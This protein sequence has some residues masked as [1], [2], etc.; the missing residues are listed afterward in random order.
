MLITNRKSA[1]FSWKRSLQYLIAL[2]L[3]TA[4]AYY[5]LWP[6]YLVWDSKTGQGNVIRCDME[7]YWNG[8][9][10]ADGHWFSNG[11]TRSSDKAHSGKY[12]SKLR[13][14][15]GSFY[16]PGIALAGVE[17]GQAYRISLWIN[18]GNKNAR[19]SLVASAPEQKAFY[20]ETNQAVEFAKK[21]WEQLELNF[22]LPATYTHKELEVY[23]YSDGSEAVFVDDLEIEKIEKD[24]LLQIADNQQ[25]KS[26]DL[27][28]SDKQMK[29]LRLARSRAFQ[30]GIII[31][32]EDSWA[33]A[34]L[35]DDGEEMPV[36]LRLKGDWLDHLQGDKWS[37]RIKVKD[38]FSWQGLKTFSLHTPKARYYLWE[39]LIHKLWEREDVLAPR[40]DFVKLS[41]NGKA[42]GLYAYE[43][44]FDKQLV[45]SKARREGPII[46]MSE[47]AIWTMRARYRKATGAF[48]GFGQMEQ[49]VTYAQNAQVDAFKEN[50]IRSSET[51][52]QQFEIGQ[53]LL[54]QFQRGA[55][56]VDQIFD[57]DRLARFYA[58][59]D[60]MGAWH[61]MIWHNQ[62]YYYNPVIS[63]LEPIGY[64]AYGGPPQSPQFYGRTTARV[65]RGNSMNS[66]YYLFQNEEFVSLYLKY[67]L[68]Y[69]ARPYLEAFFDEIRADYKARLQL[70]QQEF[71]KFKFREEEILKRHNRIKLAIMPYPDY[72]VK[73]KW[74]EQ[75]NRQILKVRNL[76]EFP[77]QLL[78]F[79][80][81]HQIIDQPLSPPQL[82]LPSPRGLDSLFKMYEPS[83]N[84]SYLYF[85]VFGLDSLFVGKVSDWKGVD[86]YVP[87]QELLYKG[88]LRGSPYFI[89]EGNTIRFAK[90]GQKVSTPITIPKGYQVVFEAGAE[91]DF[92]GSSFFLS[93][94]PVQMHGTAEQPIVIRSSDY[95]AKGFTV[96]QADG[97]SSLSYTSFHDFN[98]LNIKGWTLTGAVTFYECDV[99][100]DH[101]QF[102]NALCEDGLNIIRADV[103]LDHVLVS[104]S[105]SDGLDTD[106]CTGYI[107]NSSFVDTGNDGLDL[108]G[109]QMKVSGL[110]MENNGDK[111]ISVGENSKVQ[112]SD[113]VVDGA[114]I[115]A[116]SKDLSELVVDNI[117]LNDCNQGFAAYQKKPEFG[118]AS[119]RV[120]KYQA[121]DVKYLYTIAPGCKLWLDDR[122]VLG[123]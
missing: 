69:S 123:E 89:K 17:P 21:G 110:R 97:P 104:G 70:I 10:V 48:K 50:R 114:I 8:S 84:T 91:L 3:L 26:I 32:E 107:R 22:V 86:E 18:K 43:E 37:F 67:L 49:G 24:Y 14:N 36:R 121:T 25:F 105:F 16:G 20:Q 2:L 80:T 52:T 53:H 39:W 73:S 55:V 87:A 100:M 12:S 64:D 79:G 106:F 101:C 98:T 93:A 94:S 99:Q 117:R 59:S 62:R 90:G 109:S 116:A 51:L 75:G 40:Y 112:A 96:L 78:G 119:I 13:K 103:A 66:N 58:I 11:R 15:E 56:P 63:K 115:G 42:L 81:H 72:S 45:E 9:F 65:A 82:L 27:K 92:T 77:I 68:K 122:L 19:V 60:F 88:Q 4:I 35:I 108:S 7:R 76:H 31:T 28:L 85:K 1:T 74:V 57:L 41:L 34:I 54:Y 102:V 61:G 38:P 23:T 6:A 113:M 95:S 5:L 33:K 47:D 44:H 46:K 111:G 29:K 118:K 120:N 71:P 83:P 30:H